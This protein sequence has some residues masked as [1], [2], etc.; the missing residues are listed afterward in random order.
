VF[1]TERQVRSP[2]ATSVAVVIGLAASTACTDG[3]P[4]S[5]A[6]DATE[7]VAEVVAATVVPPPERTTPF[8]TAMTELSDRLDDDPPDDVAAEIL[9]VYRG[10]VDEVPDVIR[11]DFLAVIADLADEG[12]TGTTDT[13]TTEVGTT[14]TGT[15]DVGTTGRASTPPVSSVPDDP[16]PDEGFGPD[17][18][19]AGRVNSYVDFVCRGVVNNPGPPDTQPL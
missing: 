5:G 13:G 17:D 18:T 10:I 11:D 15:T 8:C 19:P 14:D 7:P 3:L 4:S 12:V 1:V 9:E 16:L 2:I 6:P